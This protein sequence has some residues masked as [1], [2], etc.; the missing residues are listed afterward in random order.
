M[1]TGTVFRLGE[2]HGFDYLSVVLRVAGAKAYVSSC[3]G[4]YKDASTRVVFIRQDKNTSERTLG[5]VAVRPLTIFS[6][7][8]TPAAG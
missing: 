5:E 3:D 1:H 7:A 6:L 4:R 2:E 8:P